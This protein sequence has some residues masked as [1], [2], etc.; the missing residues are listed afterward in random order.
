[1]NKVI[2]KCVSMLKSMQINAKQS[3]Y[4]KAKIDEYNRIIIEL[5]EDGLDIED[6]RIKEDELKP[7]ISSWNYR[8]HK[9][10][11]TA[12]RISREEFLCKVDSVLMYLEELRDNSKANTHIDDANFNNQLLSKIF[13]NFKDFYQQLGRRYNQRDTIEIEDEYDVQDLIHAILK[14]FFKDVRTEEFTPSYAGSSS[15]IDFLLPEEKTVIEIKHTRDG[16]KDKKIGDEIS[17]DVSH[18]QSH[19]DCEYMIV[20]IYGGQS[21]TMSG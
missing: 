20:F 10:T 4:E 14:L 7:E 9:K 2:I 21:F 11:F 15:R 6:F 3:Y 8:T 19:P 16:L 5:I 17:I 12:P 13:T 18:Y 1:M